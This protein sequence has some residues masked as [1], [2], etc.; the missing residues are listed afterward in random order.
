MAG[1]PLPNVQAVTGNVTVDFANPVQI[2]AP[3]TF[4]ATISTY[5]FGGGSIVAAAKQRTALGA[6]G[7]GYYRVPLQWNNGNPISSAGGGPT[8]ISADSWITNI[9]AFGGTPEIV[10]GGTTDNNFTPADAA[11]MVRHFSG[12]LKVSRWVIGN[13][14]SNGG[15]SIA[16]YCSLF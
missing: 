5:A 2:L 11:N 6:L 10:L 9:K 15:M 4:S 7:L 1:L 16:N 8:N 13:E 12:N 14:P 3:D